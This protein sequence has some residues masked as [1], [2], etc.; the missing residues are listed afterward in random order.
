[1]CS[2]LTTRLTAKDI[3]ASVS[4]RLLDTTVSDICLADVVS[5]FHEWE[6]LASYLDLTE[7]DE[8][9]IKTKYSNR[10][11][12]MRR[13]ALRIWKHK[14]GSKATYRK[15]IVVFC[16]QGRADVAE[17]VRNLAKAGD[18]T[19]SELLDTI[20][21]YLHDCYIDLP[22]ALSSSP[23]WPVLP[24]FCYVDL[25]L[26]DA[27]IPSSDDDSPKPLKPITLE[28][29]LVA[30]NFKA[31]RKVILVEG[32]SGSGKTTLSRYACNQWA[33]GK[34]FKNISLLI[35][36]SVSDPDIQSAQN[37][38][39]LIPHPAKEIRDAVADMIGKMNG[40]HICFILDA[41][42]EAPQQFRSFLERFIAGSGRLGLSHV[43]I[44][45]FSRPSLPLEYNQYLT[46][47]IMVKGFTLE[48]LYKYINLR[49][50]GGD[51]ERQLLSAF[52]MNPELESL[53]SLPLNAAILVFL[54]D[55]FKDNLPNTRT[56]LF[57]P[58]LC[59]HL[60]R[61]VRTREKKPL[62]IL[63]HL[64]DDLPSEIVSSFK[65]V[66][67]IAYSALVEGMMIVNV[68]FLESHDFP[69]TESNMLGLLQVSHQKI[70]M[71][72]D[73]QY[74]SFVHLSLQEFLAAFYMY[75]LDENGQL[76][77]FETI[78]HQNPLSPVLTFYS[79]LTN[80]SLRTVQ[81]VL[82]KVLLR[83][84]DHTSVM[85]S[86][87][88]LRTPSAD[89]RRQLLALAN[90]SYE[91]KKEDIFERIKL[92]EDTKTAL[93]VEH[94]LREIERIS[95]NYGLPFR[96]KMFTLTFE[97]MT[98]LPSDML[99]I[100]K[101]T[102][103]CCEKYA[104]SSFEVI[105]LNFSFCSI[106]DPEFKAL[107]I[108]LS[109]K[110]DQSSMTKVT[111]NLDR[112]SQNSS[113]AMSI[114][115]LIE[116][117]TYL[118]GLGVSMVPW[119]QPSESEFFLKRIIEG[120]SNNSACGTLLL[121]CCSLNASHIHSLTLLLVS[122][123]NVT[124]LYLTNNDLS[125]GMPLF[126]RALRYSSII[127]LE[128][129]RCKIDD[130]ALLSLGEN[131]CEPLNYV[132]FLG[133]EDNPFTS[134]GLTEFLKPLAKSRLQSLGVHLALNRQ[135]EKIITRINKSR[136]AQGSTHT[137]VVRPILVQDIRSPVANEVV[138]ANMYMVS[139]PELSRRPHH[140]FT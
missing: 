70:T 5:H 78:F 124:V 122:A 87:L 102:R 134:A 40:K 106:G 79:G 125:Q 50:D 36:V 121:N 117:R 21:S 82:L 84:T 19:Q 93:C 69:A 32:I 15:L 22:Q 4:S 128:L 100:G 92:P 138:T 67:K 33:A 114:K 135:Q 59:N 56:E 42:D 98:L 137:L 116:G 109:K 49:F 63:K 74:Y 1:M 38:S 51:R 7:T 118:A 110:V 123:T 94:T 104:N 3:C 139:E 86:A 18:K 37:L 30:G 60:L 53:C 54:Y 23:Q 16:S 25:E 13:E 27:P 20:Y 8:E 72:G 46:G 130:S 12:L 45:L 31:K 6:E 131:L 73:E 41:C 90:C 61:H 34:L 11:R 52:E 2:N 43:T 77:A 35:H 48:S 115:K 39:D 75:G 83:P 133:I 99:S 105:S 26:F 81:D 14:N 47:K 91:S 24:H 97:H 111:L 28:S 85:M 112:V 108:N 44:V 17:K 76:K 62:P 9:D 96:T 103:V 140:H 29:M 132:S 65:K 113:T 119:G 107:A 71:Y 95:R 129:S 126:S 127:L 101:F 136:L 120:L 88:M 58:L 57:Y 10:P 89:P 55:H 64:P 80:L 66:S 68:A